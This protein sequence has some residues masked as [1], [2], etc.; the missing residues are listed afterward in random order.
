MKYDHT[1]WWKHG[2]SDVDRSLQINLQITTFLIWCC[3]C[4]CCCCCFLF[5]AL[6]YRLL[7]HHG[8]ENN[9]LLQYNVWS[10]A[11]PP[12]SDPQVLSCFCVVVIYVAELEFCENG[13]IRTP[14]RPKQ[15]SDYQ[16]LSSRAKFWLSLSSARLDSTS[17]S[18]NKLWKT[19]SSIQWW[20]HH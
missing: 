4:C 19:Y 13:L 16:L 7:V 6:C 17:E 5:F 9:T 8:S 3:C 20:N 18:Q 12:S 2:S 15:L 14:A 1:Y 11:L 10:C